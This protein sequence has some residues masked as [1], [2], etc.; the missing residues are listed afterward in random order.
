MPMNSNTISYQLAR[1]ITLAILALVVCRTAATAHATPFV[2]I[3]PTAPVHR[4]STNGAAPAGG[5]TGP[6][7][8]EAFL[9]DLL[10]RQLAERHIPGATVAV[11]QDGQLLFANGYGY[12]N[13]DQRTPVVADHTLFRIGS[14]SKLFT[15]TAV[16]QLVEQGKL[17]LHADVNTY[18]ADF[19]I[20]ATYAQPI[21]LAHLLTHT[22]GFEDRQLGI[23][24]ASADKLA[25]LG[26]YLVNAMPARVFAPGTVTAD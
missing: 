24:V 11:V 6:A 13:L 7:E 22:A 3:L 21:T 26:S 12:A 9:D 14:V 16:L 17:D 10:T 1:G 8:L 5:L 25:P 15:W 19:Q 18:L 23:T 4:I 2:E 20:P